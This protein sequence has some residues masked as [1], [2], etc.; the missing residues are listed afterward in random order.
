MA[1]C[2]IARKCIPL[3][4]YALVE[5]TLEEMTSINDQIVEEDVMEGF[6]LDRSDVDEVERKDELDVSVIVVEKGVVEM[7]SGMNDVVAEEIEEDM[8]MAANEVDMEQ[9][10]E[11][12][13]G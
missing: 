13:V 5:D 2:I 3:F 4:A 1:A 10:I 9:V 6:K 7:E 8:E 12:V 11:D